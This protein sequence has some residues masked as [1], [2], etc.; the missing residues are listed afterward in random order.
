MT[1][2]RHLGVMLLEEGVLTSEQLDAAIE[3]QKESGEALAPDD[4]AASSRIR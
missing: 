1:D 4:T 2:A 3:T